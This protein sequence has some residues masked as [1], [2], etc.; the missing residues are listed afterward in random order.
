[1]SDCACDEK[2][3]NPPASSS[4]SQRFFQKSAVSAFSVEFSVPAF[5]AEE[6]LEEFE[7]AIAEEDD[8]S[9]VQREKYFS[10]VFMEIYRDYREASVLIGAPFDFIASVEDIAGAAARLGVDGAGYGYKIEVGPGAS[11]E[12]ATVRLTLMRN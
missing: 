3:Q 2:I 11:E 5:F 9:P 10:N 6:V 1:M 12:D 7:N 8:L 4:V